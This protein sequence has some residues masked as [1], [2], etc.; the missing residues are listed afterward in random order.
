[1]FLFQ[2]EGINRHTNL[3]ETFFIKAGTLAHAIQQ[4]GTRAD[5]VVFIRYEKEG[6]KN[7][8]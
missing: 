7:G 1:M 6:D 4:A 5:N 2:L 8:V 3:K